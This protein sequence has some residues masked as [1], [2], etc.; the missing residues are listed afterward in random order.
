MPP[1]W[2]L[3]PWPGGLIGIVF[4]IAV[5]AALGSLLAAAAQRLAAGIAGEATYRGRS[6]WLGRSICP[7]CGA[8]I[9]AK[10][11]VPILSWFMLRARCRACRSPIAAD[12]ALTEA[13]AVGAFIAALATQPTIGR[14]LAIGILGAVLA[15][16]TVVD[17]RRPLLPDALP[18]PLCPPP[19]PPPLAPRPRPPPPPLPE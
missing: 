17:L 3:R 7:A 14:I 16:L 9:A 1:A 15:A 4:G 12:Y 10:D 5:S 19:A 8:E 11:L 2:F 6:F 18:P 13:G